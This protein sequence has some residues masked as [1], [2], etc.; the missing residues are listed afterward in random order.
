MDSIA[1]GIR[2]A[3]VASPEIQLEIRHCADQLLQPPRSGRSKSETCPVDRRIEQ[4]LTTCFADL[5]GSEPLRLP[6]AISLPRYGV[7]REFSLPA[8]ES[9]YRNE[10][11]TS[12]RV[13]NGVLHNPRSDRRTTKG[14]FHV[15]EGGLPIPGDKKAVPRQ[16]FAALF[17]SAL[18]SPPELMTVPVTSAAPEPVRAFVSLLLRPLVCP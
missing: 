11:V 6:P 9:T 3:E 18:K 13:N 14:T 4:Y 15:T 16:A 8:N 5:V 12:Y 7:A 2:G 17:R 10:Y 1:A